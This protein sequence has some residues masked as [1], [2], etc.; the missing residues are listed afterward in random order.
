MA[1]CVQKKA[2]F[3]KRTLRGVYE[4]PQKSA[5]RDA[6]IFLSYYLHLSLCQ[7]SLFFVN[8]AHC[9]CNVQSLK[10]I[11]FIKTLQ[12]PLV[13]PRF[14]VVNRTFVTLDRGPPRKQG[15]NTLSAFLSNTTTYETTYFDVLPSQSGWC[16]RLKAKIEKQKQGVDSSCP[17]PQ[18]KERTNYMLW[19]LRATASLQLGLHRNKFNK[20]LLLSFCSQ[21][22]SS[23][24][25]PFPQYE[26]S[27]NSSAPLFS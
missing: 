7:I 14:P 13:I 2:A 26:L 10:N 4:R 15:N 11:N 21:L 19:R 12:V 16:S 25:P 17:P 23:F 9:I 8:V 6:K 20:T 1:S 18:K 22:P 27:L 5:N 24:L 3:C